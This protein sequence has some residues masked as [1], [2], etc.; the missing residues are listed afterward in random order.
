MVSD[1][2]FYVFCL[3]CCKIVVSTGALDHLRTDAEIATLLGR[4]DA[5]VII[6]RHGAEI[7]TKELWLDIH[8]P[9]R[10][11]GRELLNP[12]K[13]LQLPKFFKRMERETNEIGLL[14]MAY[15]GYDKSV[16]PRVYEK[17]AGINR[18][19]LWDY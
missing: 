15:A 7:A 18:F 1:K 10:C 17:L 12:S 14:L 6:A 11:Y 3:P 4:E 8:A 13:L 2:T 16:A 9:C 19:T 5:H